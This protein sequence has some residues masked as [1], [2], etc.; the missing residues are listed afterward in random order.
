MDLSELAQRQRNERSQTEARRAQRQQ[1]PIQTGVVMEVSGDRVQVSINGGAAVTATNLGGVIRLG[2]VI[3]V[4]S[5]GL[6]YWCRG[7]QAL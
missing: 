2:E 6:N 7:A 4:Q 3:L 5:D 1:S